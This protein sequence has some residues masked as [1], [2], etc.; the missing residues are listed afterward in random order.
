MMETL[1]ALVLGFLPAG[2]RSASADVFNAKA[3]K[4]ASEKKKK[5]LEKQQAINYQKRWD[6]TLGQKHLG[7]F[8]GQP[9]VVT[10]QIHIE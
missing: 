6:G 8:N 10:G 3:L 9:R 2:P 4:A 1:S 7:G 5:K